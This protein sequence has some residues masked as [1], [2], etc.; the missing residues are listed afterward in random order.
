MTDSS[1]RVWLLTVATVTLGPRSPS[2]LFLMEILRLAQRLLIRQM[3][4]STYIERPVIHPYVLTN[5]CA[6]KYFLPAA[7]TRC[8]KMGLLT[9]M[10]TL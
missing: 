10:L 6:Y 4:R 3:P 1:F 8:L 5:P 9:S 2:C 7:K